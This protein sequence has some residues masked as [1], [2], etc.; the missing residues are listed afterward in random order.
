MSH[1][2]RATHEVS[3]T[4]EPPPSSVRLVA[5]REWPPVSAVAGHFPERAYRPL[6]APV[7]DPV[8]TRRRVDSPAPE[9]LM[10]TEYG[11]ILVLSYEGINIYKRHLYAI[12]C[13]ETHGGCGKRVSRELRFL[14]APRRRDCGCGASRGG[15]AGT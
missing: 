13:R 1:V 4:T 15:T 8:T 5:P 12:H 6:P 2:V 9:L 7:P 3:E 10:G 14:S 11:A